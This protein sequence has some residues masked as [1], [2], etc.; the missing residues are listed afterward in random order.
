M[1]MSRVK[2]R[3]RV[4]IP[5]ER[6]DKSMGFFFLLSLFLFLFSS[7]Q[8]GGPWLRNPNMAFFYIYKSLIEDI[9]T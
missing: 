5:R 6:V 3:K 2:G 4:M 7:F 8:E 9:F 1:I